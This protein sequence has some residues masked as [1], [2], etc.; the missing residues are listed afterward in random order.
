MKRIKKLEGKTVAIVGLGKSWFE[1]NLAASHGD[2]F[3][4]VWGINAVGSVIFH[5]RTF[6][7][8]PPSRFLDSEDAGG[9]TS[10]M[11]RLLLKGDKPIYT[12]QLDERC[13][14]LTLY[15]I[16]E[17]VKDLQCT[18]LNNTVAYAVAFAYWNEVANL[19]MF[20]VDFS[21]KGN[22]HFAEAGRGCVEFWLSKC[23]SA[24]MQV[25]VAH[26]SGLLD[27]DVPAEQKLYGYH[28][29]KNPYII[30]VDEEGIKL[31]RI[32]NLEI[33]KKTQEPVLIDRHDSH[34]KPVEPKKW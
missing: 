15:P 5:D 18:Y 24:G 33:V 28:R 14:N 8:D 10:G 27:T 19:K 9:Q 32:D 22:L 16:E 7:M 25:E 12:C 3:D 1:Y 21:Y 26:T 31:E 29:L 11:Q 13:K 6:M 34:L 20:G 2:H 17:I 4:E 30:L 23:I